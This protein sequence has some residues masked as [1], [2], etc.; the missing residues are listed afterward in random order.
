[1]QLHLDRHVKLLFSYGFCTN[2]RPCSLHRYSYESPSHKRYNT[3]HFQHFFQSQRPS[4]HHGTPVKQSRQ[5]SSLL[6]SLDKS[7]L[8]IRDWLTLLQDM[9]QKERVDLADLSSICRML[10]RQRVSDYSVFLWWMMQGW[11]T[12][13]IRTIT[14]ISPSPLHHCCM[15][16]SIQNKKNISLGINFGS[17]T[18]SQ[19]TVFKMKNLSRLMIRESIFESKLLVFERDLTVKNQLLRL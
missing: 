7:I 19:S 10:D 13:R 17:P 16:G 4:S 8:Q 6:A 9:L 18:Q 5:T 12:F 14:P 2:H 15:Y 3:N 11:L 1:M